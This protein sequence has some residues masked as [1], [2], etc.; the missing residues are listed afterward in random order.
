[1]NGHT[2]RKKDGK[3]YTYYKCANRAK[4]TAQCEGLTIPA[5]RL[6]EF[7]IKTLTDLSENTV[8]L[9]DKEKM[10]KMLRDDVSPG[11]SKVDDDRKRLLSAEKDLLSRRDN[12][13]DALERELV[14]ETDFRER[15]EKVKLELEENRLLQSRMQ[16]A[17]EDF[18]VT[19]AAMKASFEEISSFG[20]NWE[21][22]D[23]EG[24]IAKI[25]SI[26]KRIKVTEENVDVQLYLDNGA[27]SD[28]A[29]LSRTGRD[30]WLLRAWC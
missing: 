7:I 2:Y 6:E 17:T 1:M 16:T 27:S 5:N 24:R 21:N 12:L 23:I 8:F 26:V 18:D 20:L 14:D 22:L 10:M 13:L 11:K 30:S 19:Q 28:V 9:Q 29:V 3:T 15:Y 4:I 25:R